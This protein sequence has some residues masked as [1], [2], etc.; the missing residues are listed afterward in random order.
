M[1]G[2]IGKYEIIRTIG[3]GSSCKV[4]LGLDTETG[5]KVAVKILLDN[6]DEKTKELVMTEVQAMSVLDHDNVIKQLEFGVSNYE[7]SNGKTKEVQYIV[8]ELAI[9]GEVFDFVAI[10]GRFEE[11]LARYYF[12]QFMN[13]LSYCHEQGITHRDLKPENLL[14]DKN[15]TL[16]I[17]DFGFAAPIEGRDGSGNLTTK[18]G[19]MN[20][21]APE[22]H[23]N[24]PYQGEQI[25]VFAAA[26]ILFIMVAQHPPFTTAQPSDPFYRC[27]AGKRGDIFWRTHC[28]NKENG[29]AFFTEEFKNLIESMLFL[30]PSQRATVADVMSHPW[31]QGPM[32]TKEQVVEE[33]ERRD[34]LVKQQIQQNA[35]E[36][37]AEKSKI[38][39]QRK[40]A[41]MRSGKMMDT[42]LGENN[43]P[44][45][46]KGLDAYERIFASNTEFFSTY[47]PEIIQDAIIMNLQ[48]NGIKPKVNESKYKLK[49][50]MISKDQA[51]NNQEVQMC[52]RILK[53]D[54]QKVCVE[55]S[56]VA[57]DQFRFHQHFLDFKNKV[58]SS[59]NDTNLQ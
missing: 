31:M 32:P 15:F 41:A 59:L 7:K 36:K 29:E 53:V 20:Y 51:G 44:I 12:T 30:E 5:R 25:D 58:L 37:A 52:C 42:E 22:I 48:K 6:I 3:S 35:E 45:A 16:K 57:G 14:L 10:S 46:V 43:F 47:S 40:R 27:L 38:E 19:T 23:L 11:P 56:K 39:E 1:P 26:I 8:M 24:Q 21:M 34:Q 49:F 55:F 13:G 50:N 54:D 18:L 33:F 28:K 2:K 4:K 9:G 17:A